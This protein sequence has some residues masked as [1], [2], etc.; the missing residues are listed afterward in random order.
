MP[1]FDPRLAT[2][3]KVAPRVTWLA[4]FGITH[5]P[6]SFIVP[7]PGLQL[8]R[9]DQGVQTAVQMSQGAEIALPA[10]LTLT[11]TLF[12][13]NYL[14]LTDAATTCGPNNLTSTSNDCLDQRVRGQTY[15]IEILLRRPLTKRLTGWVAYT[16]SRSTRV[17]PAPPEV[18]QLGLSDQTQTVL[19]EFDRT[20]VLNVVAAYDLGLNW[21]IGG[22]FLYY[23]GRPYSNRFNDVPVPPYNSERLP[24]FSASTRGSRSA[25]SPTGATWRSSPRGS[26]SRRARKCST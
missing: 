15:G 9:L 22:R 8:A 10:E 7:V 1:T 13:H 21:R 20:H 26:T 19:S 18:R 25:G 4:A 3:V 23:T 6:P 11:P 17:A 12:L 5:Q 14:N 2:R 24:A 16:L